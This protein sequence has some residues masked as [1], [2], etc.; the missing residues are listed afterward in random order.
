MNY[1]ESSKSNNTWKCTCTCT[2]TLHKVKWSQIR[3]RYQGTATRSCVWDWGWSVSACVR[4]H[5]V[6]ER[7][8]APERLEQRHAVGR[9]AAESSRVNSR[10]SLV[11]V[12]FVFV[13]GSITV[14]LR[15][16]HHWPLGRVGI[17]LRFIFLPSPLFVRMR[18]SARVHFFHFN[19]LYLRTCV[20][21]WRRLGTVQQN[22]YNE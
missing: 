14:L 15:R 16:V 4:L 7:H 20:E 5:Q 12:V 11:A 3:H 13:V 8:V 21:V 19:F 2:F 9:V 10:W 6:L 18:S 22:S 17:L 1:I